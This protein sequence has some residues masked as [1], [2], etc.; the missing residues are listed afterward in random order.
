[1]TINTP[2][3]ILWKKRERT[4]AGIKVI[5]T[6]LHRFDLSTNQFLMEKDKN[7]LI[8]KINDFL[9]ENSRQNEIN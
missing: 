7:S 8:T 9:E 4:T 2:L 5:K 6:L 1:V 3:K